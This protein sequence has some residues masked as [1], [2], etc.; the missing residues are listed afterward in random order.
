MSLFQHTYARIIHLLS[1][2][3]GGLFITQQAFAGL[4]DDIKDSVEDVVPEVRTARDVDEAALFHEAQTFIF[5]LVGI[6]TVAMILYVGVKFMLSKGNLEEFKQEAK[7][8][9]YI[10]AGLALIPLSYFVIK[11]LTNLRL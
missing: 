1:W 6:I 4:E 11:Y 3:I 9:I 10:I 7:A 5:Q 2:C 8:L